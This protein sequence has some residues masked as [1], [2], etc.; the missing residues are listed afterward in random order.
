MKYVLDSHILIWALFADEKLLR[1]ACAIINNRKNEIYYS[2]ASVWKIGIKHSK[3]QKK[4]PISGGLLA[5]S[6]DMADMLSLPITK[7]HALA[8]GLR[9]GEN[10]PPHKAPF[11]KILIAQA[12][13]EG[14][15]FLTYDHLLEGYEEDCVR[16]V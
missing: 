9:R 5:E 15:V 6:C 16:T 2:A 4:M 12:K 13:S 10:T 7:E 14:M 1:Q 11:D 3:S 8:A